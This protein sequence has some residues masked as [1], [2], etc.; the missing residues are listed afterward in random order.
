M[1]VDERV[2]T[3]TAELQAERERLVAR[4]IA[5]APIFVEHA[6]GARLTDVEG[7]EYIDFVGGI[8]VL[9]GGHT[10]ERVVA[11]I[12]EQAAKYLH[13]CYSI[14]QYEPFLEVC[15]RLIACHPG[16]G[17]YKALLVNTGAEATENAIKI[18]RYHTGRQAIVCFENA[19][20]GRTL[21]GMSLT[22][23][24]MPYKKGFGP[25]APEVYRAQAPYPYRG[26]GT[27]EALES[28]E[29]LFKSQVDPSVVA[30]MIYEPV[31][32]EGGFH[33]ATD[34]FV[35]GLVEICA[36]YGIVY[37]SDEVQSG[38]CRTGYPAAVERWGV[39]P[40]LITWGKSMG[41]GMPIAGVTGRADI[42]DSVHPGGLGG[43][44]VGNP[45]SCAAAIVA[46]DQVLDPA[47][48]EQSRVFGDRLRARLSDMAS[49]VPAIGEVRGL[50]AMLAI[51]LVEDRD[52][53]APAA[54]VAART[55]EIARANGL[56][57]MGAGVLSNVIRVL[58]PL[59]ATDADLDEG[60]EIFESAL[61]EASAA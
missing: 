22:S 9:N 12:Q 38:M 21:M 60:L 32:G 44:Y 28:V 40:D 24:A 42:M 51:E 46:L 7:R 43:T 23:K 25:F 36:R 29:R 13:Q 3:R 45:V 47:F 58:V 27:A 52:T 10:P 17:P 37:I 57:L 1:A 55:I 41:G 53:R 49:R 61:R 31:Q 39:E 59:V 50:G 30:G 14:A 2:G 35:E 4:G 15:R 19:F 11:A 34:G 5:T 6:H 26:I 18:A 16:A 56:L 20:H 54:A 33:P 48:Q 8:G